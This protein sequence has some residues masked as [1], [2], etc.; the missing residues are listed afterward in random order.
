M[1]QNTTI[2]EDQRIGEKSLTKNRPKKGLTLVDACEVY[3]DGKNNEKTHHHN[4]QPK[5]GT[6]FCLGG[7]EAVR[8]SSW[9]ISE[10]LTIHPLKLT[11]VL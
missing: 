1:I 8:G 6:C 7:R 11:N 2:Q 5:H 4:Y 3:I 10:L 9:Y